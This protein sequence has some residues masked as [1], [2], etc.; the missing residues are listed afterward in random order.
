MDV[1]D[2][3]IGE[4]YQVGKTQVVVTVLAKH[5]T[6]TWAIEDGS[7][8]PYTYP[9]EYLNPPPPV[10]VQRRAVFVDSIGI[11]LGSTA[12]PATYH[13]HL[14]HWSDGSVTHEVAS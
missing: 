7:H 13:G 10:E 2:I 4:R 8:S 5:G 11:G 1:N 9:A 3:V 6:R 14:I 12:K